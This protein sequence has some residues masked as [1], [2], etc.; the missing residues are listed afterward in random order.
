MSGGRKQEELYR[1]IIG[2]LGAEVVSVEMTQKMHLKITVTYMGN[3]QFFIG[4][5]TPSDHRTGLNFK[6]NVRRWMRS[7]DGKE[8]A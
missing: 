7:I 5:S 3:T 1:Q 4:A 8:N 2:Q 6:G